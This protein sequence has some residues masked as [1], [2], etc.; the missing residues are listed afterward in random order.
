MQNTP[1]ATWK[2]QKGDEPAAVRTLSPVQDF[3]GQPS[4]AHTQA[5]RGMWRGV[6]S[7]SLASR[8]WRKDTRIKGRRYW[9]CVSTNPS[10]QGDGGEDKGQP[11]IG[12]RKT[13]GRVVKKQVSY[14][15]HANRTKEERKKIETHD[16][17]TGSKSCFF[18][19]RAQ[20][21]VKV[22]FL[23]W[24]YYN[25]DIFLDAKPLS[26]LNSTQSL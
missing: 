16:L 3:Q 24:T 17:E 18:S 12:S 25:A 22:G 21:N 2:G 8:A 4:G 6:H 7:Y 14:V 15:G 26:H 1:A 10:G 23:L 9:L 19:L 11:R 20:E 5:Q 13:G